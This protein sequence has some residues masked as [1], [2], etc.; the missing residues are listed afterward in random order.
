MHVT[1]STPVCRVRPRRGSSRPAGDRR[2]VVRCRAVAQRHRPRT[3][4]RSALRRRTGLRGI[5]S[6]P[7]PDADAS[8]VAGQD[9][10]EQDQYLTSDRPRM[11]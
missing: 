10:H 6:S 5:R 3:M 8:T 2:N 4:I 1:L 7:R 9:E 11:E